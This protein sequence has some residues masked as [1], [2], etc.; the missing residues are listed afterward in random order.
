MI[1]DAS[2]F[3]GG[4][5]AEDSDNLLDSTFSGLPTYKADG[6]MVWNK[7]TT[8]LQD[9][10]FMDAYNLGMNSGHKI[11]RE[12]GSTKNINIEWRIQVCCWAGWHAKHL[13]GHFV[14]CGTNTG[15]MSLAICKYIDF[16]ALNKDFYLFDTFSGIPDHQ[17]SPQESILN[18]QAENEMYEECY[19]LT[20]NNFSI[21]PRAKLVKGEIPHT[22]KEVEIGEVCYLMLD[23]NIAFPEVAALDFFWEKLVPGAVVL[24]DDYGWLAYGEQK[25]SHDNFAKRYGVK[26]L[27]LPT[28]Q[29]LLLKP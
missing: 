24:F 10:D 22:L 13:S 17:I 9:K 25:A 12:K 28:G 15:I 3:R 7:D 29:G 6:L 26:I 20:K 8:F 18:R 14:E 11:G 2:F 5:L 1:S 4:A 16:N 19:E 27:T 23:M 21:F